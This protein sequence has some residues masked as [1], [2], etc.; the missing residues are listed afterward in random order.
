MREAALQHG[1]EVI[2]AWV[3]DSFLT[4][5]RGLLGRDIPAPGRGLLL[6]CC[7]SVH[8]CFM[9]G[10]LDLVGLRRVDDTEV[11]VTWLSKD[12]PPW[13][14]RTAR[15]RTQDILELRGGSIAGLGLAPGDRLRVATS[16]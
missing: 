2:T 8:T 16:S 10:P 5:G 7:S 15:N 14:F 13:R 4:R 3:A 6:R 9:R 12:V 1:G 11:E